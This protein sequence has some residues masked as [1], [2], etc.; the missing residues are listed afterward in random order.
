MM[1]ESLENGSFLRACGGEKDERERERDGGVGA[2]ERLKRKPCAWCVNKK[3]V[4]N[5]RQ[6][7]SKGG[8]G[9]GV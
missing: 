9:G 6:Y 4:G 1:T 2:A 5:Q 3:E 7:N 8:G